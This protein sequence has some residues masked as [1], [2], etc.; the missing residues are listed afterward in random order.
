MSVITLAQTKGGSGKTTT[1]TCLVCECVHRGYRT[2][3]LDLDPSEALY[4]FV[5][6]VP[7]L[8]GVTNAKPANQRLHP[9]ETTGRLI[10]KL[11]RE[12][13][14]VIVDLMGA[15]TNDMTVAMG[16]ADLVLIPSQFSLNDLTGGKRTWALAEQAEMTVRRGISKGI[17][18]TRAAP[19]SAV[20]TLERNVRAAYTSEGLRVLEEAFEDRVAFRNMTYSQKETVFVPHLHDRESNAARNW[21][22][23]FEEILALLANPEQPE[24]AK[25]KMESPAR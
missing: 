11:A 16:M 5:K 14:V 25:V 8:A 10:H 1:A 4:N 7:E 20:P 6:R 19:G 3:A 12:H 17:L 2:A 15:E 18:L 23:I 21:L 24:V 13:D 9:E 22:R